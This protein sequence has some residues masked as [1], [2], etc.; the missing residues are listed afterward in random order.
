M[1]L[2]HELA[3]RVFEEAG[4]IRFAENSVKKALEGY[5]NW[6]ATQKV[7][8]LTRKYAH[9]PAFSNSTAIEHPTPA[10]A[11]SMFIFLFLFCVV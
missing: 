2:S 6:G 8:Q 5:A 7:K 3:A 11:Q 10:L 4:M 1:A 9:L